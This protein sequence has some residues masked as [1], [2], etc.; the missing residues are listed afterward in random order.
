MLKYTEKKK[1]KKLCICIFA[2]WLTVCCVNSFVKV[3][4]QL[5]ICLQRWQETAL[6]HW[7]EGFGKQAASLGGKEKSKIS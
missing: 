7:K 5:A 2:D 3:L 6:S 4:S 1:K